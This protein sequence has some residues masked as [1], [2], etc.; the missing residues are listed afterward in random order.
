M[1]PDRR[2]RGMTEGSRCFAWYDM[3]LAESE[4]GGESSRSRP[5][6]KKIFDARMLAVFELINGL[7]A[8]TSDGGTVAASGLAMRSTAAMLRDRMWLDNIV[9]HS[10]FSISTRCMAAKGGSFA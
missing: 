4:V 6:S 7:G 2:P 8:L 10:P 3:L 1:P 5:G 9:R